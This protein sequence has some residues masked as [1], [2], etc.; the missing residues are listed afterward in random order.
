MKL[1]LID[2]DGV[3]N[4]ELPHYVTS[5]GELVVLEPALEGLALLKKKGFTCVVITNQSAVGRG[6]ISAETLERIHGS[7]RETV[8]RTAAGS[9]TYSSAPTTPTRPPTGANPRPAC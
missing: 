4:E 1:V 9:A 5:P 3:I 2:R 8:R 6:I 7:M